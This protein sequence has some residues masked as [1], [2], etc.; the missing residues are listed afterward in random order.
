MRKES[1]IPSSMELMETPSKGFDAQYEGETQ[2]G[3]VAVPGL[4]RQDHWTEMSEDLDASVR[5]V[6]YDLEEGDDDGEDENR[7][8]FLVTAERISSEDPQRIIMELERKLERLE[9][10]KVVHS[11]SVERVGY[12]GC[13]EK[14]RPFAAFIG[15]GIILLFMA[16]IVITIL[17][18]RSRNSG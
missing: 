18:E 14:S 5:Q 2:V 11:D 16:T 12:C 8:S 3:A 17:V 15:I 9:T 1:D 10:S 7:G 13:A 4:R 6:H